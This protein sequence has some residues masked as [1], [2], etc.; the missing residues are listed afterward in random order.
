M[1]GVNLEGDILPI[2]KSVRPILLP[3]FGNAKAINHKRAYDA[4]A[5]TELD[6]AVEEHLKRELAQVYPDIGY[7]G[8]EG[9]GDRGAQRFWLVDPIDGTGNFM[10]GIPV[11][12]T[13]LALIENGAPVFSA[14]Y[15]FVAD[16]MYWA[17][18]GRGAFRDTTRLQ[19][20][21]RDIRTA[22]VGFE[23]NMLDHDVV[24]IFLEL[25]RACDGHIYKTLTAGWEHAMIAAG[26]LQ[27]RVCFKPFGNDYDFAPGALLVSEAGGVVTN[28]GSDAYDFR[29]TNHIA[30][31]PKVHTALVNIMAPYVDRLRT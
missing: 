25:Y 1:S 15:D 2:V 23:V 27:G 19:V 31:S 11:C 26:K 17:S 10:R 16:R 28:I 18:K 14:I 3:H 29:D 6:I 21:D 12:T 9:G 13:M 22:W 30:A 5:V 8:E 4:S 24:D 20:S 7:V